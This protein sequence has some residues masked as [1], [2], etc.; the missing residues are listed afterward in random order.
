MTKASNPFAAFDITK[1]TTDFDPSKLAGEFAKM[2]GNMDFKTVDV[3]AIV[4][5]QQKNME[6]LNAANAVVVEGVKAVAQRQSEIF[7][8]TIADAQT[9]MNDL[10]KI[11]T[12]QDAMAKQAELMKGAFE[13][14]LS[15]MR[16]LSDMV[17]KSHTESAE[18]INTRITEG[19]AEIQ[20]ETFKLK[21]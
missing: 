9:A 13:M 11:K 12:P 3:D 8:T 18:K 16:E 21:K 14:S 5:S 19:L 10:G 20:N 17:T 2:A 15:Y 7:K 1:F 6:A 4:K